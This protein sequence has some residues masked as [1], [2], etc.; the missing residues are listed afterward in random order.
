MALYLISIIIAVAILSYRK[1]KEENLNYLNLI[2]DA[3]VW[4]V[5][6]LEKCQLFSFRKNIVAI[7]FEDIETRS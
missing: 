1:R 3:A 7:Q 2:C 4:P 6:L 5:L